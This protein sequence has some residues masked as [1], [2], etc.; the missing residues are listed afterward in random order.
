MKENQQLTNAVI[1]YKGGDASA[2]D[3][4]YELTLRDLNVYARSLVKDPEGVQDLLQNTYLQVIRKISGLKNEGKFLAWSKRIMY[5]QCMDEFRKTR[6]EEPALSEEALLQLDEM[7]EEDDRRFLPEENLDAKQVGS[8]VWEVMD[9]ISANHKMV[10]MAHYRDKMTIDEI[11]E[12]LEIPKNTVKTRLHYGREAMRTNLEE[13][14]KKYDIRV[15]SLVAGPIISMA[16]RTQVPE[17]FELSSAQSAELLSRL[18]EAAAEGAAQAAAEAGGS[19]GLSEAAGHA[20]AAKGAE[21][22]AKAGSASKAAGTA[23]TAAKAAGAGAAGIGGGKIA[24]I[25]IAGILAVGGVGF[26]I[27]Q[28]SGGDSAASPGDV[29][30]AEEQQ[31]AGQEEET[32]AEED[33]KAAALAAQKAAYASYYGELFAKEAPDGVFQRE[34]NTIFGKRL[35][36]CDTNG[37]QTADFLIQTPIGGDSAET[38]LVACADGTVCHTVLKPLGQVAMFAPVELYYVPG[39]PD[40]YV[41]EY[42]EHFQEDFHCTLTK[43]TP[44]KEGFQKEFLVDQEWSDI[45]EALLQG[46]SDAVSGALPEGAEKWENGSGKVLAFDTDEFC[47]TLLSAGIYVD[48][49]TRDTKTFDTWEDAFLEHA[50]TLMESEEMQ[51]RTFYKADIDGDGVPELIGRAEADYRPDS[52]VVLSYQN[53][54]MFQ[55]PPIAVSS[56]SEGP[57]HLAYDPETGEFLCCMD[58]TGGDRFAEIRA[59]RLDENGFCLEHYASTTRGRES[60]MDGQSEVIGRFGNVSLPGEGEMEALDQ[61]MK[62]RLK[63]MKKVQLDEKTWIETDDAGELIKWMEAE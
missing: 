55:I 37:D 48:G 21:A 17:G 9:Q 56:F 6:D 11:A 50:K 19:S 18:S 30:T 47:E 2:F 5:N 12:M 24:A 14:E 39:E 38:E 45:D 36:A 46:W 33:P 52:M 22:G 4:I 58:D 8:I 43:Y 26:G 13:Y 23:A 27:H 59:Y 28:M 1:R 20:E 15:H 61:E 53:G 42:G 35:E 49:Y 16:L 3:T 34:G 62:K 63:R 10:L 25:V 41:E 32:A 54:T 31:N 51:Y 29:N 44:S 60:G 7:I 57:P 40:V